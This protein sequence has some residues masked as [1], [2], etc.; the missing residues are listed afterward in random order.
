[1]ISIRSSLLYIKNDQVLYIEKFRT[2]SAGKKI[3]FS[4]VNCV[5]NYVK[6]FLDSV[7]AQGYQL[8]YNVSDKCNSSYIFTIQNKRRWKKAKKLKYSIMDIRTLYKDTVFYIKWKNREYKFVKDISIELLRMKLFHQQTSVWLS[9]DKKMG[10]FEFVTRFTY[11]DETMTERWLT[12]K[13]CL[14]KKVK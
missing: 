11:N 9:P 2:D 4:S 1:M 5:E 10:Y 14:L 7:S 12:G 13:T 8:G 6:R 3:E